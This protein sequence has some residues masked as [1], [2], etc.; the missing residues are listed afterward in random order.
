MIYI[1]YAL[2]AVLIILIA[3]LIIRAVS[4]KPEAVGA[5]EKSNV[6][7]NGERAAQNLSTLVK[8]PTV[9]V[10]DAENGDYSMHEK[11]VETLLE[12]YPN[13]ANKAE[14][15]R[16]EKY[17]L[18]FK[19][20]G[21]SS[22]KPSVLMSHFDVVPVEGQNWSFEPFSG[23][24]KDG[25]IHGRGTL[26]TKGTLVCTC[27]SVE[28][29][30]E[31]GFVPENDLYLCFGGDEE[32]GGA[33][34]QKVVAH[35]KENGVKPALVFDEGGAIVQDVFPGVASECAVVG[36]SE[37]GMCDVKLS[38]SASG[39]HA[40][41]PNSSNPVTVLAGA[42]CKLEK[43]Q[44][45]AEIIPAVEGMLDCLGRHSNFVFRIIF[46]N[47]WLF[48]PLVTK[49]FVAGGGETS[50]L[51]KTTFAFTTI[52]GSKANNVL[53]TS[54]EMNINVR[55]L[56]NSTVEDM[57]KHI[58]KTIADDRISVEVMLKNEP[59][60][61]AST[62]SEGYEKVKKAMNAVFPDVVVSPYV[63]LAASDSR[64][65]REISD[66]A[67][68]FAPFKLSKADR[69]SIHSANEKISVQNMVDGVEFY[70]NLVSQL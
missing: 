51:C 16:I 61:V 23:E 1:L 2:I 20:A 53:P 67:L 37:K 9:S 5:V 25:Y 19:I 21:K 32:I 42:I 22:E 4:F 50:A 66:C 8:I 11:F 10:L 12:M 49:I 55:I 18:I 70:V 34:C 54:A 58:K 31:N 46:A 47:M 13:I 15:T 57:V 45:K 17:G 6:K 52:E 39:G 30:L 33:I 64:H 27:E 29:M 48:K 35:L 38:V 65:Y 7:I 62:K 26:D 56:N 59:S 24:V 40:S 28:T 60:P 36:I 63:M 41:T 44:M 43:N 68:K 3:V 69:G 14:F